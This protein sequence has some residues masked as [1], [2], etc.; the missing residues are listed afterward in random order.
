MTET[1]LQMVARLAAARLDV[2]QRFSW[3]IAGLLAGVVYLRWDVWL[4]AAAAG[5]LGYFLSVADYRRE[6]RLAER[7]YLN[8]ASL[9]SSQI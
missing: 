8:A 1:E 7:A 4:F 3:Y 6:A 2:A 5:A 9:V